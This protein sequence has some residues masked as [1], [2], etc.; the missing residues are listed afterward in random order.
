[1]DGPF[2]PDVDRDECDEVPEDEKCPCRMRNCWCRVIEPDDNLNGVTKSMLESLWMG[3]K[4]C[5]LNG[6]GKPINRS[7][8]TRIP[9]VKGGFYPGGYCAGW[10]CAKAA[11]Q[12]TGGSCD[13]RDGIMSAMAADGY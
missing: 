8:A 9:G 1:L 5:A 12:Q 13:V 10:I 11:N 7:T 4:K 3:N 2:H 6:C